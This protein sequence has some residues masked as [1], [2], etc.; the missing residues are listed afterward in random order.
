M[1]YPRLLFCCL[2]IALLTLRA[3]AAPAAVVS[4]ILASNVGGLRDEDGDSSDWIELH[5][6]GSEPCPLEGW[7]LTDTEGERRRWRLPVVT[8][9]PD[10]RLVVF[11]SGKN[12]SLP[13]SP[14]HAGF[15][16][17]ADGGYVALV[18]PDGQTVASELRYGPQRANVSFGRARERGASWI[19]RAT[20]ARLRVP[21]DDGLGHRWTGGEEPFDDAAWSA[22]ALPV[23]FDAGTSGG[24]LVAYWDFDT[25]AAG[26]VPDRSPRGHTG[27]LRSAS[28]TPVGGG[29]TGSGSDRAA[30]FTGSGWMD[31]PAAGSGMLDAA[32][33]A[34][35]ITLSLWI[36][37]D[38]SQP[39]N[40]SLFWAGSEPQGGG[41]RSLNAH[42][43][44]SDQVIYWDTAGCCDPG[45][46]RI[47]VLEPEAS[48]WR[49]GWNHYAFVKRGAAKEI[50]QNGRLLLSG[51]GSAALTTIRSLYVGSAGPGQG[52]YHGDVDDVALWETAL[53]PGLIAALAAG[54][55]PLQLRR[56]APWIATDVE[57]EVRGRNAS[58]YLRV[59]FVVSEAE[60]PERVSMVL[61]YDDGFIAFL[62]GVEVARR[63]APT[64]PTFD[65]AATTARPDAEVT[66]PVEWEFSSRDARLRTGTNV[67]AIHWLNHGADDGDFLMD[68][69]LAGTRDLGLRHFP[70]PTPGRANGPGLEGL[71]AA[72][73]VSPGRGFQE[74]PVTVTLRT[75]SPSASLAYTVDGS[76]PGP[77]NGVVVAGPETTVRVARTTVLRVAAFRDGFLASP[78]VTHTYVFPDDVSAQRRP[79]GIAAA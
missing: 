22:V 2:G 77:G 72:P 4:E 44:W 46:H 71:V 69:D 58:A 67:L 40:D 73:E 55:S 21:S 50:W 38:E 48:R 25:V 35:A 64:V 9:A 53:D 16:L 68:V 8:L 37:G 41:I 3:A 36:R 5:N 52:G 39:S 75:A 57:S 51:P 79:A 27:R 17:S 26:G 31:V 59:P 78:V 43:P 24:G 34:D 45:V 30:R 19:S 32:V 12:R 11:A 20:E 49:D 6:P 56:L 65:S 63:A 14:L 42:L 23:G 1:D 74:N 10:A 28:L 66:E 13:A 15:R 76:V 29:R 60:P 47:S 61:R 33:A 7:W 70:E 54:A 18:R 62:N